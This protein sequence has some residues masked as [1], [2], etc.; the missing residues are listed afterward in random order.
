MTWV[1]SLDQM[2]L[3]QV[4]QKLFDSYHGSSV[5]GL[6]PAFKECLSGNLVFDTLW[7]RTED[8]ASLTLK[9]C[10]MQRDD[11]IYT[12][13]SSFNQTSLSVVHQSTQVLIEGQAIYALAIN[14]L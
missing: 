9:H 2:K 6:L 1:H 10:M 4:H 13:R 14:T 5:Q 7:E 11:M 8:N 12:L 3:A